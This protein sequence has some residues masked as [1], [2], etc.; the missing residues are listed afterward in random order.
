MSSEKSA[1]VRRRDLPRSTN[2]KELAQETF[3]EI[4]DNYNQTPRKCLNWFT[5]LEAF[6]QEYSCVALQT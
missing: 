1:E 6:M 5:P 2:L 3:D 4:I